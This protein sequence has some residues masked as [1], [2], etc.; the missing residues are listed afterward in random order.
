MYSSG[1]TVGFWRQVV[2][3]CAR[4]PRIP[5]A[6]VESRIRAR[7]PPVDVRDV[8][9]YDVETRFVVSDSRG[10]GLRGRLATRGFCVSAPRG[11]EACDA[12]HRLDVWFEGG[13]VE[14]VDDDPARLARWANLFGSANLPPPPLARRLGRWLLHVALGLDVAPAEPHGVQRYSVAKPMLGFV[15]VLYAD[16]D[17]RVTRG[18]RGTLVITAKERP[19][20]D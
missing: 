12:C 19:A 6:L 9:T 7:R 18:N 2:A 10:A 13:D 1:P 8:R 3:E 5:K 17:H 14:P 11:A 16:G 20:R 15:D 4:P